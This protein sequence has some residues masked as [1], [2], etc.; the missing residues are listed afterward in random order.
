M[1]RRSHRRLA[2]KLLVVCAFAVLLRWASRPVLLHTHILTKPDYRSCGAYNEEGTGITILNPLRSRT[3]ER[4]GDAF[5]R[6]ASEARCSPETS[7][8]V[9]KFMVQRP[10]LAADWRLVYRTNFGSEE[11]LFFR[12][13]DSQVCIMAKVF[14]KRTGS[15]WLIDGYGISY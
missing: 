4:I 1:R 6:A 3:A 12:G 15:S 13:R 7:E 11:D 14:L 2:V 8:G 5:L 9:C 10:L